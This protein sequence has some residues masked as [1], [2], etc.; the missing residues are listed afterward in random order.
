MEHALDPAL[1]HGALG[2]I[3]NLPKAEELGNCSLTPR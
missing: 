3:G 1:L 2:D